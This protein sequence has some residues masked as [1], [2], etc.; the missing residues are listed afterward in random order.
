MVVRHLAGDIH[1]NLLKGY[2]AGAEH[3]VMLCLGN[4]LVAPALGVG[5]GGLIMGVALRHAVKDP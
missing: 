5:A 4:L 1:G 3:I 2:G